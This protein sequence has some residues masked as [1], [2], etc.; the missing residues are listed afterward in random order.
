MKPIILFSALLLTSFQLLA[1]SVSPSVLANGGGSGQTADAQVSWT[2]GEAFT[3][4]VGAGNVQITQGFQQPALLVTGIG[5]DP[6][7]NLVSKVYPNPTQATLYVDLDGQVGSPLVFELIDA[8]GRS[9]WQETHQSAQTTLSFDLSHLA[10]GNYVLRVSAARAQRQ[11]S[12]QVRKV[13]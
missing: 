12:Y 2:I 9:L 10:A 13:H 11:Q 3:T 5:P 6:V 8:Q 1:Q 7:S 4:T